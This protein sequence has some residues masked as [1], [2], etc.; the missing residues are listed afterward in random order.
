[1][2]LWG[3]VVAQPLYDLFGKNPT[4]LTAHELLGWKLIAYVSVVSLLLPCGLAL[5][6]A[7]GAG[8]KP[9]ARWLPRLFIFLLFASLTLQLVRSALADVSLWWELAVALPIGTALTYL[10]ATRSIVALYLRVAS[11]V[12]LIFPV[13]F[14][15]QLPENYLA[16]AST[17]S[18]V[19][20]NIDSQV[21]PNVV[22][23]V[24]D[25]LALTTLLDDQFLIDGDRYPNFYGLAQ[26]ATWYKHAAAIAAA[27][28]LAVPA[29]LTGK[30]PDPDLS[31][32]AASHPNNLFALLGGHY[33]LNVEEPITRLCSS[34]DCGHPVDWLLVA[35]DTLIVAGHVTAPRLV[36]DK[37]PA[38]GSHWVGFL[39]IA[40]GRTINPRIASIDRFLGR[41]ESQ[42]SPAFHFL[43]S[44]LPHVPYTIL[45][46]GQ[47]LFRHGPTSGNIADS[48]GDRF[49]QPPW[50]I[51]ESR[52]LYEW[53]LSYADHT[54]GR[55]IGALK[56]SGK[57]AETLLIVTADHGVR[58]VSGLSRREPLADSFIDIAA[59]PL[60]VKYPNQEVGRVDLAPLQ[61]TDIAGIVRAGLGLAPQPNTAD[62]H[63][64]G[65]RAIWSSTQWVALPAEFDF[66]TRQN[67][68]G[69]G[70][71]QFESV[72]NGK[73]TT[74]ATSGRAACAAPRALELVN[75]PLY[76]RTDPKHFLAAHVLFTASTIVQEIRP[77]GSLRLEFNGQPIPVHQ[78]SE[79]SYSAFVDPALFQ[80]GFN[81]V[82]LVEQTTAGEC[83]AFSNALAR[84]TG[85]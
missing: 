85:P 28:R 54:L 69:A 25:E 35:T 4:F 13:L 6:A 46:A 84:P 16:S 1:M 73:P 66:S 57:H 22:L 62:A 63:P 34:R 80:V 81:L 79:I 76:L 77:S 59:I 56:N 23:I 5:F 26:Q 31:P 20:L 68:P 83:L 43:H 11:V 48:Q 70:L 12:V 45:P 65:P 29:I 17:A 9:L 47:R 3:F 74:V 61:S 7:W 14:I 8:W 38:I 30:Q 44:V 60:L 21:A 78:T 42:S 19:G 75:A 2:A 40:L 55:I 52:H 67:V 15:A 33:S 50:S 37:L 49:T 32:D 39:N 10:Y 51:T 64:P 18:P 58:F 36:S 72:G 71:L 82:E 53:Q 27:T 24:F 41:L